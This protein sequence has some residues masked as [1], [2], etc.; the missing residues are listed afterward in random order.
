MAENKTV[1]L[2]ATLRHKSMSDF[3]KYWHQELMSLF[4]KVKCPTKN[5][6]GDV[7]HHVHTAQN[8]HADKNVSFALFGIYNLSTLASLRTDFPG[9]LCL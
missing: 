9:N 4:F 2:L 7:S 6:R 3:L 1:G 5:Y 8:G